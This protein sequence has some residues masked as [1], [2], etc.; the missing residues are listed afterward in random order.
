MDRSDA[1]QVQD[2]EVAS[3]LGSLL[4]QVLTNGLVIEDNLG[5]KFKVRLAGSEAA[6]TEADGEEPHRLERA[7]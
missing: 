2:S 7:W 6:T 1:P 5:R 4:A 3:A